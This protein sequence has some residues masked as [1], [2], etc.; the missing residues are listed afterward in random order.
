MEIKTI[1]R[2]NANCSMSQN[3]LFIQGHSNFKLSVDNDGDRV[4]NVL[5]LKS[6]SL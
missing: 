1:L 2:S 6:F 3:C 5:L 4:T